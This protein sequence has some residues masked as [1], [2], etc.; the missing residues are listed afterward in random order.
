MH[1]MVGKIMRQYG[2]PMVLYTANNQ[3]TIYGFIHHTA[4][5]ARKYALPEHGI[6]G[7][8]PQ[9]RYVAMVPVEPA[10]SKN[11]ILEQGGKRY[12]VRRVEKV[13]QGEEALYRWCLCEEEGE[14]DRWGS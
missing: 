10:I 8:I 11:D 4:T 1:A 13:W 7:E 12:V 2:T 14:S 9:G 3:V 5:T 6:L